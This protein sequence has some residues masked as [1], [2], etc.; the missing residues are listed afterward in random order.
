[1]KN[2]FSQHP[3]HGITVV[4]HTIIEFQALVI[5]LVV[6]KAGFEATFATG[7]EA[8]NFNLAV[9]FHFL[10]VHSLINSLFSAPDDTKLVIVITINEKT[11]FIIGYDLV[12]NWQKVPR[13]PLDVDT[14]VFAAMHND[15]NASQPDNCGTQS[16]R[17]VEKK[18]YAQT[19]GARCAVKGESW[20]T[21]P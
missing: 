19:S 8:F 6:D 11:V 21:A 7:D 12:F 18:R 15:A 14:N 3:S 2:S 4:K 9:K 10:F 5:V 1:M 20:N 17:L 16:A 13:T